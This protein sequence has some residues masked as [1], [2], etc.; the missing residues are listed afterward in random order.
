MPVD[1]YGPA[2]LGSVLSTRH[3]PWRSV[4]QGYATN[5]LRYVR[6]VAANSGLVP[7]GYD[8]LSGV[9]LQFGVFLNNE[10]AFP[11][12]AFQ[13]RLFFFVFKINSDFKIVLP[14]VPSSP[15]WACFSSRTS[16]FLTILGHKAPSVSQQCLCM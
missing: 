1:S 13:C 15:R 9:P 16:F 10:E 5:M 3:D 7:K 11:C 2:S 8:P 14:G 6:I 12:R 4:P